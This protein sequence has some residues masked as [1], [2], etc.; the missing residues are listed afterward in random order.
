M[1][2]LSMNGK[3]LMQWQSTTSS[4]SKACSAS[5]PAFFFFFWVKLNNN[6]STKYA[7]MNPQQ[8]LIGHCEFQV[9]LGACQCKIN[10]TDSDWQCLQPTM[11]SSVL[12]P[13]CL[14]TSLWRVNLSNMPVKM[15]SLLPLQQ[16]LGSW[17]LPAIKVTFGYLIKLAKM[18]RYVCTTEVDVNAEADIRI[19]SCILWVI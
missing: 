11:V 7:Q 4:L 10:Y 3:S 12:T 1:G 5:S 2:R 14:A 8:T 9:K 16:N 18:P 19:I 15:I 6:F 17:W 13:E